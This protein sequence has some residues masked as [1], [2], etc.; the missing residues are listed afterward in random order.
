MATL[1]EKY[2]KTSRRTF[3]VDNVF[4][5][6]N[7]ATVRELLTS[8]A[9]GKAL[10]KHCNSNLRQCEHMKKHRDMLYKRTMSTQYAHRQ[11]ATYATDTVNCLENRSIESIRLHKE[12]SECLV[13]DYSSTYHKSI[14]TTLHS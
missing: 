4:L 12:Q 1:Q 9:N 2:G 5:D 6:V 13:H 10:V 7:N 8:S 3:R 14:E 11:L